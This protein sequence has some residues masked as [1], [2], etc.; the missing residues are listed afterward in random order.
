MTRKQVKKAVKK[1]G[2]V[3]P[4]YLTGN[5]ACNHG[6]SRCKIL[7]VLARGTADPFAMTL[8]LYIFILLGTP[9]FRFS[10]LP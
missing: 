9:V 7:P 8:L 3:I 2:D 4:R 6:Q 1:M 10:G 5:D